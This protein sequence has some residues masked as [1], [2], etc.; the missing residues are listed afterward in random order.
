[1]TD[2]VRFREAYRRGWVGNSTGTVR[3]TFAAF[4]C[5]FLVGIQVAM[6]VVAD[7]TWALIA[8]PVLPLAGYF[9]LLGWVHQRL[10]WRVLGLL[11]FVLGAMVPFYLM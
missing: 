9:L 1:V 3:Y 6:F 4:G 10:G 7:N 8:I 2:D 5:L 11:L